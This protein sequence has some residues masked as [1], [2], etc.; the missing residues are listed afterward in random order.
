MRWLIATLLMLISVSAS[1]TENASF[2][3]THSAWSELLSR[4]VQW[5]AEGT[6]STVDYAGFA[7]DSSALEAYL[8]TLSKIDRGTFDAWKPSDR[9]AFLINAY[10]AATVKLILS[11]YPK[12]DSIK[13]LGGVFSS[14]WKKEFVDLLGER[15]SLDSIEHNLLRGA[16]D[17]RDPRIHFAVNCA[18]IGCP[19]LR[20]EAFVGAR[21]NPQLQDQ[22]SR[23]LRDRSRNFYDA[24]AI[25]LKISSIFD[26]YAKD[27][28]SL[29]G[30]VNVFLADHADALGLDA[31]TRKHL[32]KGDIP[33]TY[34]D[35]DW[36]LNSPKP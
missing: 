3:Q 36:K 11:R 13:D 26:W 14:P 18:S 34:T 25:K 7:H 17:Y 24:K 2:D 12:L 4:H 28:D 22:T 23:F 32:R 1:G 33:L 21:L 35:Y 9:R 5:N 29:A 6:T 19:A 31:A 15:R 10:N 27:F 8:D 20:P 30:G 16:K